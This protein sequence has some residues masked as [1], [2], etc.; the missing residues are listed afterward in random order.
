[1][2]EVINPD[3]AGIDVGSAEMWVC[4]PEGRAEPRR[5]PFGTDTLSLAAIAAWL[6]ECGVKTVALES[7]GVYWIP[8]FQVLENHGLEVYLVNSRHVKRVP[9]RP[10]T[11]PAD[12]RWLQKLHACG[13]LSASF[14]PDAAI[15][16]LR[17]YQRHRG[18]LVRAAAKQVQYMQKALREMNVLL[19]QAVS[20]VS[21][22]TGMRIMDAIVGGQRDPKKLAELADPRVRKSSEQIARALA[23]DYRPEHV[24][25]LQQ[26]LQA[27]RFVHTRIE[28]CDREVESYLVELERQ[29]GRL[30]AALPEGGPGGPT[31]RARRNTPDYDVQTHLYRL[32]GVD[33]TR[34][35]GIGAE[36]A[37]GLVSET[38]T[39]LSRWLTEKHFASWLDLCPSPKISGGHVIGH[40]HRHSQNRAT[41]LFR[42]A[43]ASLRESKSW[44][45]AYYRR[46]KAR[47][48]PNAANKA[49][50]HK[51]ARIYYRMLS[52]HVEY[53]D[54]GVAEYESRFRQR[55]RRNLE[56]RARE[57]GLEL[58]PRQPTAADPAGAQEAHSR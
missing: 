49:T 35:P 27:Y 18:N 54:I 20:D 45:G 9:G 51:L 1:M 8:L 23:G 28:A 36:T 50:A 4:V 32:L 34:V 40:Q 12:C 43:A 55:M 46:M 41:L 44:L 5:R 17:S 57:F 25:V 56:R 53:Q 6:K 39:D 11:D 24:F 42:Q 19:D 47:L 15:C 33:L 58:V 30:E 52:R 29:A 31:K 2:F 48:G 14:R 13:L 16:R 10:K 37:Q 26:A 7:T 21:G 3:A 38:G 22:L